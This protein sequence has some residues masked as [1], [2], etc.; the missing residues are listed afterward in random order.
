M[1][2]VVLRDYQ[3]AI[4]A[5]LLSEVYPRVN[6]W[7]GMG[8]GKSLCVLTWLDMLFS[9]YGVRDRALILAPLRVAQ[10]TW[11]DEQ[12]KW[13][14]L[15][16]LTIAAAVGPPDAR[17][18]AIQSSARVVTMN[19][20]NL[21]WL[22]EWLEANNLPWP[23]AIV[24]ADESTRLKSFRVTQGALRSRHLG[25]HAHK[26]IKAFVNL[27]GTPAPNGLKD[28]WGQAWFLDA[29][30]RLGLSF[31]AF[32]D[33]WFAFKRKKDAAN[34]AKFTIQTIVAPGAQTEI[35]DKLRDVTITV[36]AS[37]FLDLP[38]LIE[39]VIEVDL[40]PKARV[41]Y[42]EMERE[43]FLR[44]SEDEKVEAFNAASLT[45]KCLQLANGAVYTTPEG[46]AARQT[47]EVHD[48]KIEALRSVVEEA[49]GAP[50]L[51]A[52]HF[53]SDLVRLQRAF[54]QGRSLG[55]EPGVISAWNRGEVP[56]L[57]AHPASAGHGLNLQDGGNILV[58]FG[59][60]WD[61]EQHEQIIE[62]IGPTRQAQSGYNRPVFVH[63]IV[64]RKTVD[65]LVLARL[66]TKA[67]VQSLLLDAMKADR[68]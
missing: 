7:S 22:V 46:D 30:R 4:L 64:A 9:C 40:P 19:Y 12:R 35:E 63:R 32:E 36:R 44:L 28:L 50:V 39:N 53:K 1:R 10:S 29:G 58:F 49:A 37:D 15:K 27:T 20:E 54:P 45:M 16:G 47:I 52:Y 8:T 14:H 55:T 51:V 67:S 59:L 11:P 33:R 2:D 34:P 25:R 66:K 24:V 41:M 23:F 38:P 5:H 17:V 65:E 56:L 26:A 6:I 42:R 21:P 68:A 31:S 18:R 62:R 60:W 43:M 3:R 61:L 57:F 48:A 13:T